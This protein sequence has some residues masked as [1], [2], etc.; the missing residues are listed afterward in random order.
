VAEDKFLNRHYD[1]WL[2]EFGV[3]AGEEESMIS[4]LLRNLQ[5]TQAQ[6]YNWAAE[7]GAMG[8]MPLATQMAM[9]RGVGY[10]GQQAAGQGIF[11]IGQYANQANRQ[12]ARDT[13]NLFMRQR[14]LEMQEQ[15]FGEQLLGVI[16]GAGQAAGYGYG[17][18]L[19]G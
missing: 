11:N 9:Q 18:G 5:T 10:Q 7:M 6:G 1:D 17:Y 12:A 14:G 19:A 4:N 15:S 8:N 16:S 13:A 2:K 3:S